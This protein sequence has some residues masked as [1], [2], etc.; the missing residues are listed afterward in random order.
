FATNRAMIVVAPGNPLG[1]TGVDDLTDPDLIVVT[2]APAVPCGGYAT[3][4]FDTAD[5]SVTPD[6]LERNVKSVVTK[7]AL[8]EADAGIAYATDVTAS[9]GDVWGVDIPDDL[10]VVAEYP[11]AIVAETTSPGPA[12]AFIEFV[13]SPAGV[14][15]LTEY[16]FGAP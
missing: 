1:I 14:A 3:Q 13:R 12:A 4:I 8:G 9:D 11:I 15:L 6:S 2:C 5:V 7:V 16:G 10:N